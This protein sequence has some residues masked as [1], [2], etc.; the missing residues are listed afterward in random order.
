[1]KNILLPSDLSVQSLWPIKKI[2]ENHHS[3]ELLT[4]HVVH[5]LEIPTSIA[6]LLMLGRSKRT[7]SSLPHFFKDALQ[8]LQ[9]KFNP[10]QIKIRFEFV[11]GSTHRALSNLM[12]MR[13]IEQVMVLDGYQYQFTDK[14]SV[15]FI[16][17][18][19]KIKTPVNYIPYKQP[20]NSEFEVLSILL[21]DDKNQPTLNEFRFEPALAM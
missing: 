10:E 2:A 8:I 3:P 17:F 18:F 11:Y 15:N 16:G 19:K 5:L 4:I 14:E 7:D 20:K 21:N 13:R 9:S 12:D 1:M 6:D